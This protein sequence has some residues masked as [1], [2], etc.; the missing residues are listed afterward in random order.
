[1]KIWKILEKLS[2]SSWSISRKFI[3][4]N[5]LQLNISNTVKIRENLISFVYFTIA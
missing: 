4:T 1:M 2:T 3:I 5:I